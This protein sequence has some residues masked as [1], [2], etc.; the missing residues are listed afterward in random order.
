[1]QKVFTS[2]QALPLSREQKSSKL[3]FF[4]DILSNSNQGV[5]VNLENIGFKSILRRKL[6]D[7]RCEALYVHDSQARCKS[8]A[9]A[10]LYTA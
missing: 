5:G 2:L 7:F 9:A 8:S 10:H 3:S 4:L 6:V 1:M